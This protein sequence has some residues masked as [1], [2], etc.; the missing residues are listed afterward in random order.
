MNRWR[1]RLARLWSLLRL[2]LGLV[3]LPVLIAAL[4]GLWLLA[5]AS[6]LGLWAWAMTR[7]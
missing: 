7:L 5:L 6:G 3:I 2:G 1:R 4:L